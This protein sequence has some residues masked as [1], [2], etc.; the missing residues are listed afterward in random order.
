[1]T[2]TLL[3]LRRTASPADARFCSNNSAENGD[4]LDLT[5][6]VRRTQRP[7]NRNGRAVVEAANG[8]RPIWGIAR[9][10]YRLNSSRLRRSRP[11]QPIALPL[12][13]PSNNARNSEDSN[14]RP[15]VGIERPTR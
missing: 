6:G 10:I 14:P 2:H 9:A 3:D 7:V 4:F 15:H 12:R 1:M 8:P 5:N 11:D 13:A